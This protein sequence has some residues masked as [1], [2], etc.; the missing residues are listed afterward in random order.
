[1]PSGRHGRTR[2]DRDRFQQHGAVDDARKMAHEAASRFGRSLA[3]GAFA[4]QVGNRARVPACLHHG[5][6]EESSVELAVASSVETVSSGDAAS[7]WKRG[8]C[9]R[10]LRTMPPWGSG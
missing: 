9:Q 10:A 2:V 5:D 3:F 7:C 1:M 4:F 8:G 6:R